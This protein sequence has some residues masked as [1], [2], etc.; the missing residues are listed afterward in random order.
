MPGTRGA[1]RVRGGERPRRRSDEQSGA[2]QARARRSGDGNDAL[3][4]QPDGGRGDGPGRSRLLHRRHGAQPHRRR[5]RGNAGTH[6]R[7]RRDYP[8]RTRPRGGCGPHQED[9]QPR[10]P[11][12]RG[13]ARQPRIR[14]GRGTC[15]LVRTGRHSRLLPRDPRRQLRSR[16]WMGRVPESRQPR[17]PRHPAHRGHRDRRRLR[18]ARRH[19]GARRVLPRPVRL[20]RVGRSAGRRLRP[21][22]DGAD[23]VAHGRDR[24]SPRQVRDD[25]G[26]RPHRCAVRARD[27]REGGSHDQLQ[28]RRARLPSRLPR[29]GRAEVGGG[30]G[31]AVVREA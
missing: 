24:V 8:V 5:A 11:G 1:P 6:R 16:G 19:P 26:R 18:G 30:R 7:R 17:G 25:L 13:P 21:P 10:R 3:H 2:T 22:G 29:G 4:G 27:H 15:G 9:A 12:H 14:A 31:L 28:R 20:L 23:V